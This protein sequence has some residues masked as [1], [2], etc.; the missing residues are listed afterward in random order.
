MWQFY[1]HQK[2]PPRWSGMSQNLHEHAL[3]KPTIQGLKV[4]LSQLWAK[5]LPRLSLGS[6]YLMS[7]S[8]PNLWKVLPII[9]IT[10]T[11]PTSSPMKHMC[12]KWGQSKMPPRSWEWAYPF[13]GV[14]IAMVCWMLIFKCSMQRSMS[15]TE[16]IG[17]LGSSPKCPNKTLLKA[18]QRVLTHSEMCATWVQYGSKSNIV[19]IK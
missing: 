17:S 2:I 11:H 4:C 1:P 14:T 7:E 16:R 8:L 3:W 9:H 12:S 19:W 18:L 15:S 10:S 5:P 13:G 6:S